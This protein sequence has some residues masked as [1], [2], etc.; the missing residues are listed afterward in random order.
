MASRSLSPLIMV[1]VAAAALAPIP[2]AQSLAAQPSARA[3]ASQ[4]R[5]PAGSGRDALFKVCGN[6]HSPDIAL[7][8]AKT[9]D[10]WIKTLD[11]MA[12]NGALG[13]DEEWNQIQAYLDK[14]YSLIFVNTATAEDLES[15]LDVEP[16]VAAAIV[17]RRTEKGRYTSID[18]LK[19]VSGVAAEAIDARKDRLIF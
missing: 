14:N 5:F 4:S 17:Q 9:H 8:Q 18:G 6:C 7:A 12:N 19:Q 13:S 10:E 11:E 1:A 16:T 2:S 3:G 15:V